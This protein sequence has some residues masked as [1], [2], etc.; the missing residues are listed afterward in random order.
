MMV[1][2]RG[3][4]PTLSHSGSGFSPVDFEGFFLCRLLRTARR[5]RVEFDG[6]ETYIG[7]F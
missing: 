5:G 4:E 6:L 3:A 2:G 1:P 7:L